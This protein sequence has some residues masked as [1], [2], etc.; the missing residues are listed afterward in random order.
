[1]T[2]AED[3]KARLRAT[4]VCVS[5]C[6]YMYAAVWVVKSYFLPFTNFLGVYISIF[7]NAIRISFIHYDKS[8]RKRKKYMSFLNNTQQW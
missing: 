3:I 1:M 6:A 2:E 8:F 7:D 4:V 5:I